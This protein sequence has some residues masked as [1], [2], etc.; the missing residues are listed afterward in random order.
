MLEHKFIFKLSQDKE[1]IVG[2]EKLS[3]R[4]DKAQFIYTFFDN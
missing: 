4:D 2:C 3:S 1:D